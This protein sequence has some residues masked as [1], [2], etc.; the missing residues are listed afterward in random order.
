MRDFRERFG[1]YHRVDSRGFNMIRVPVGTARQLMLYH[2][3][4]SVTFG[5]FVGRSLLDI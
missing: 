5:R 3:N 4:A 2:C 1:R